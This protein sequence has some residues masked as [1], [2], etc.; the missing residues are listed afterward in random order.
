MD[1]GQLMRAALVRVSIHDGHIE[2]VAEPPLKDSLGAGLAPGGRRFA[3]GV[4]E[5]RY[6]PWLIENFDPGVR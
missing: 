5:S 1:G 6:D 3:C 4:P 2:R